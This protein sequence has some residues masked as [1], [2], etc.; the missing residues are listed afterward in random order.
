MIM[1]LCC[2]IP[3]VQHER[4]SNRKPAL[5]FSKFPTPS[6]FDNHA[7]KELVTVWLV[8]F[9]DTKRNQIAIHFVLPVACPTVSQLLPYDFQI[10]EQKNALAIFNT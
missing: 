1:F 9:V 3:V 4:N 2:K 8:Y 6:I 5:K 7:F 10:G